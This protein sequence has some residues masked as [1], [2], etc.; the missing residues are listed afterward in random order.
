VEVFLLQVQVQVKHLQLQQ[1]EVMIQVVYR[2]AQAARPQVVRAHLHHQAQ[3]VC[4]RVQAAVH[5][6]VVHPHRVRLRVRVALHRARVVLLQV[7][8]KM[9]HV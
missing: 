9:D 7:K 1:V 8:H 3:V 2:Q 6:P 5:L 4:P